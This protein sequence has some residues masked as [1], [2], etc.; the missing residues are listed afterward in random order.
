[1]LIVVA[2][3]VVRVAVPVSIGTTRVSHETEEPSVVKY[4]PLFPV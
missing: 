3:F 1:M 2:L 4:F